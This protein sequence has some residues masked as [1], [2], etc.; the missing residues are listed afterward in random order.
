[1]PEFSPERHVPAD[2]PRILRRS[3]HT[4]SRSQIDPEALKVLYRLHRSGYIAC[5]VGGGVRDLLLHRTPKDFDIGTSAHPNEVKRLFGNCRLIGRRF[6]LAH[7]FFKGGKVIEVSTFRA[8]SEFSIDEGPITSD[9]TF[10]TPQDDVFRRDFTLNALL[11]NIADF[12]VVDYVGGLEDLRRGL[13]RCI[14]EPSVRFREDPIRM[15]RGIRF[16]ALLG[17]TLEEGTAAATHALRDL[18]WTSAPPRILEEILRTFSRGK[19]EPSFRLLVETGFC[20][21]LFPELSPADIHHSLS[22]LGRLDRLHA[23]GREPSAPLIL[24]CVLASTYARS[25]SGSPPGDPE[26]GSRDFF[27]RVAARLQIPR[28]VCD[29][30]RHMFFA[31]RRLRS[32]GSPRLRPV[33]LTRKAWFPEAL[34]LLD[35]TDGGT[36]EGRRLIEQWNRLAG[37]SKPTEHPARGRRRRPRRKRRV[38]P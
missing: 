32:L 9:N 7:V 25:A 29:S 14:G 36:E 10:G 23:Q 24:A 30:M 13:V 27:D 22:A 33:S 6:R 34:E 17:F 15:L 26:A 3:E 37:P 4:I 2:P 38:A 11:Y 20:E 8:V 31:Q 18:I 35:L 12:S 28:R 5:L 19:A 16:A 21:T 1:M